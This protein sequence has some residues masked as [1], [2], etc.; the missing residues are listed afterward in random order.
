MLSLKK[1]QQLE[2]E[3]QKK[4]QFTDGK[5]SFLW[6]EISGDLAKQGWQ[7]YF[8]KYSIKQNQVEHKL[9]ITS[10]KA[11]SDAVVFAKN[12]QRSKQDAAINSSESLKHCWMKPVLLPALVCALQFIRGANIR[13]SGKRTLQRTVPLK[14][15]STPAGPKPPTMGISRVPWGTQAFRELSCHP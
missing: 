10:F 5:Q 12:T 15:I 6:L 14:F 8:K 9:H 3:N 1:E 13:Q 11:K 7:T 2:K 4:I